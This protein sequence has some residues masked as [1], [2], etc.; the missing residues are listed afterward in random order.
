MTTPGVVY[1]GMT[2]EVDFHIE[3][4]WGE[5]MLP[6]RQAGVDTNGDTEDL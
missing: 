1:Q 6:K 4:G 3:T 2:T 5:R